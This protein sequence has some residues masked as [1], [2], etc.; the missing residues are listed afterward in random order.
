MEAGS[1][2]WCLHQH[3]LAAPTSPDHRKYAPTRDVDYLHLRL[4]VTPSFERKTVKGTTTLTF[5]P[6]SHPVDLI[7]LDAV[8]LSIESVESDRT[9]HDWQN[10]SEELFIHF[11]SPIEVGQETSITIR[12]EAQPQKGMYFRTPDMG[13]LEGE[14][15]LFTQGEAIESRH[16]FPC[17]DSPNE[18]LTTE[19]ICHVPT[20]MTVLSNGRKIAESSDDDTGLTTFHWLQD[21]PHVNYL[22]ALVAG[23]FES[24]S[25]PYRDIPMS[26]YT[27]P[28]QISLAENSFAGTS[29]MMAFIEAETGT[30]YPWDRYDQVCVNDFVAGGMENTTL[31]IL[32]DGTLFDDSTENLRSSEGLVAHELAHQWFG[33]LVTCKDWSHLW[34]NEG[35]ASYFEALYREHKEG[36]EAFR[37]AMLGKQGGWIN[38]PSDQTPIA[39]REYDRPMQQFSFRAYPKAAWVLHMIRSQIGEE[40]FRQ[41]MKTYLA[42]HAFQSVGT[43]DF[44]RVLEEITGR[45][46][47]QFFDQY[48]YHGG[49]PDLEIAYSWDSKA[50]LVKLSVG[51]KQTVSENVLLFRVPLNLEFRTHD[52][53]RRFVIDVKKT[54]EDFYFRLPEKPTIVRADP[55]L[56]LLARIKIKQPT[57]MILAQAN[58]PTDAI[59]RILAV[60]ELGKQDTEKS[61]TTLKTQLQADSFYGVRIEASKA[62]ASLHSPQALEA[63]LASTDQ[64][65]A[66]VRHQVTRDIATFFDHRAEDFALTAYDQEE[67]PMIKATA[68]RSLSAFLPENLNSLVR[69][70]LQDPTREKRIAN[71]AVQIISD[72]PDSRFV[73]PLLEFL[74][75]GPKH[76]SSRL[77]ASG[78][79]ALA[80]SARDLDDRTLVREFLLGKATHPRNRIRQAA[81]RALGNLGDPHA[82]PALTKLAAGREGHPDRDSAQTALKQLRTQ[83]PT[84]R[85]LRSLHEAIDEL[86]QDK[87]ALETKLNELSERLGAI[88]AAEETPE[89][90]E[91]DD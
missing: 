86:K 91:K 6:I 22:I 78:L 49:H 29:D 46:F 89:G 26:F 37:Y 57:D 73:S 36:D 79:A 39:N 3:F 31:T 63:L 88:L 30:P 11:Q 28:S 34:L 44:N 77:Y 55:D 23:P 53:T 45:S 48:V 61:L 50:R 42:R 64:E 20:G 27:L 43:E 82:I 21:K 7:R 84:E 19:V 65:D 58:D 80:K 51:Q 14:A 4:D 8:D 9:L 5:K 69:Q 13:Y 75:P 62:L 17:F 40:L 38:N 47:D 60:R 52:W 71:A 10:T 12:H 59:G 74:L 85:Q 87:S 76:M 70:S 2:H 1:R 56:S 83:A 41:V 81:I 72:L 35:F 24:I 67:N 90:E 54:S 68:T 18:K 32:T 33:D 15:H 66:R 16:W 25:A